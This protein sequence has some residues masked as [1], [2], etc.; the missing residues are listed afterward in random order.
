MDQHLT[1][2][3]VRPLPVSLS[4]E[5]LDLE[6]FPVTKAPEPIP[7]V[8]WARFPEQVARVRAQ[9]VAWTSRAVQIEWVSTSG[10]PM[11]AWVWASAVDRISALPGQRPAAG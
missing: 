7:V 10:V 11:T 6:H 1:E 9:A 2:L 8:A 5:E 4:L 3:L